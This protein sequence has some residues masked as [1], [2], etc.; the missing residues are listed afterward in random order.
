MT[1]IQGTVADGFEPVREEFA[2][3]VA[4]EGGALAAQLAAYRHGERVVDLWTGPEITGDSLLGAFSA[5]KGAAH[6]V[7]ALLVQDGALDLDQ[8]VSHYWPEF[9]V[10][11]KGDITLR[12]L[13]AHRA[14]LVGADA[15]FTLAELADD[16]VVAERLG[17]QRPYWRPGTAFGYH[18]LVIAAL[19]GEVVRRAT[20]ETIQQHFAERVRDPYAVDFYLGLPQDQES[21]F[22]SAQPMLTTPER[23]RLQP[24]PS[25]KP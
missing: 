23:H 9:A 2:A 7:T 14:G 15:G 10:E 16:R 25:A 5:S 3:A 18:A 13:L 8:K 24:E 22:L 1:A 21:R 6:L 19:T 17:A 12:E 4:T 11:D 20:G